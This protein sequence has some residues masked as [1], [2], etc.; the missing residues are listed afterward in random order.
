MARTRQ[1]G[2][3]RDTRQGCYLIIAGPVLYVGSTAGGR[4]R[5]FAAR[6][7]EHLK[8]LVQGRHPNNALA[9]QFKVD[10]GKGWRMVKLAQVRRGD[11]A[12]ARAIEG[13]MIQAL[14]KAVCNERR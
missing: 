4:G 5:G 14:G 10:G 1:S 2:V 6:L 11:I 9:R 3:K 12:Q 7:D 8:A 13:V